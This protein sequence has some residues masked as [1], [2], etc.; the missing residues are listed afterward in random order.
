[1]ER[2][3][4]LKSYITLLI[5]ASYTN[6]AKYKLGSGITLFSRAFSDKKRSVFK[7]MNVF[8]YF[9]FRTTKPPPCEKKVH[10]RVRFSWRRADSTF[11]A[12]VSFGVLSCIA[13][14]S[15]WRW[16]GWAKIGFRAGEGALKIGLVSKLK[17]ILGLFIHFGQTGDWHKPSSW[18]VWPKYKYASRDFEK[19]NKCA[20]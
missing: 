14:H 19:K 16:G 15:T 7:T 4:S 13:A 10:L 1:M 12:G 6:K 8:L 11:R 18:A 5:Y 17:S 2:L 20:F 9:G 3:V